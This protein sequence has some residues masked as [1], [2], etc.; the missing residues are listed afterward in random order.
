MT[1]STAQDLP[2]AA[3]IAQDLASLIVTHG[4]LILEDRARLLQKLR[5]ALPGRILAVS[6]LMT[7]F[8]SGAVHKISA[9]GTVHDASALDQMVQSIVDS[10]GTQIDL[11]GWA[12]EVWK[13][14]LAPAPSFQ[15]VTASP[16]ITPAPSVAAP[17]D[18]DL[19][20]ED[21]ASPVAPSAASIPAPSVETA[22]SGMQH[23]IAP[24]VARKRGWLKWA[25]IS[26]M[27]IATAAGGLIASGIVPMPDIFGLGDDFDPD[28]PLQS[29]KPQTRSSQ[30]LVMP[31]QPVT[32]AQVKEA[33]TNVSADNRSDNSQPTFPSVYQADATQEH[34]Q[35]EFNV[36]DAGGK[37]FAYLANMIVRHDGSP[38]QAIITAID[39]SLSDDRMLSVSNMLKVENKP[40]RYN[41]G[42]FVWGLTWAK[43][44]SGVPPVCLQLYTRP[45]QYKNRHPAY[46]FV[47]DFKDGS[48]VVSI[49]GGE[50]Q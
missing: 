36:K 39:R 19:S 34:W 9:P 48:C 4:R 42:H 14:A 28:Y 46:F 16:A 37:T 7:A 43:N 31:G 3:S 10:A 21:E 32:A 18:D 13:L 33:R 45:P 50:L 11:A 30:I 15:A 27:L 25:A 40:D 8:D 35:F 20:W 17:A 24:P 1:T 2:A 12:L 44:P 38:S 26:V 5:E 41:N 23:V 49:G 22:P 29:N 6:L 47:R